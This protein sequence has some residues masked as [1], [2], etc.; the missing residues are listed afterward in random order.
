MTSQSQKA[1]APT[2]RMRID[3]YSGNVPIL[4][5][6]PDDTSPR[7]HAS[8]QVLGGYV[9]AQFAI[10]RDEPDGELWVHAECEKANG[11]QAVLRYRDVT[12]AFRPSDLGT[13]AALFHAIGDV[14][15]ALD[16]E[17]AA[18]L[19]VLRHGCSGPGLHLAPRALAEM[20]LVPEYARSAWC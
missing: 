11:E 6:D 15:A 12:A 18:R 20:E 19:P 2:E 1:G 8:A 16:G 3:V 9:A 4:D 7:F 13:M 14:L 5:D 17:V 10:P